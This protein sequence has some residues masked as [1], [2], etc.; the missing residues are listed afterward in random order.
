MAWIPFGTG[1]RGC[2]GI[3]FAMVEAKIALVKLL[4]KYRLVKFSS[5]L[6]KKKQSRK[7]KSIN[8]AYR[9]LKDLILDKIS[10]M[11]FFFKLAN[12]LK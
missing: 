7:N 11:I 4:Q 8:G 5:Y 10:N 1:P 3:R 9:V 6:K 12:S 2:L